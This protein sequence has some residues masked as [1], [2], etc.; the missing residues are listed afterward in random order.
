MRDAA[1]PINRAGWLPWLLLAPTAGWLGMTLL[2]ES[3]MFWRN[4]GG[5]PVELREFVLET[6]YPVTGALL[7]SCAIGI[8]QAVRGGLMRRI[9][10]VG[11]LVLTLAVGFG[12]AFAGAN[13]LVN[14]MDG[15][16]LHNH[17]GAR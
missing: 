10:L 17:P 16:P 15:R 11:W 7:L 13:N 8:V 9:T 12:L 14:L 1:S 4:A 6:Y 5:Y 2:R 3:P